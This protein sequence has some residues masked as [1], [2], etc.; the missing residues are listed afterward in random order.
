MISAVIGLG[1]M[2]KKHHSVMKNICTVVTVDPYVS[3]ADYTSV[4]EML[5]SEKID[6]AIVATPT[7]VHCDTAI[8]LL[9]NGIDVLIEKPLATNSQEAQEIL[10]CAKEYSRRVVVGHIE[11][12]NPATQSLISDISDQ[13]VISCNITRISPYPTRINDVGV[14]L[15][16]AIHDIDLVRFITGQN[17][18]TC[19]SNASANVNSVEDTASFFLEM[20]SGSTAVIFDSWL[21][22]FR[23]RSMKITT[24]EAYYEVDLLRQHAVK[25]S[26]IDN[27]EFAVKDLF[28]NRANAL[29]QQLKAFIDYIKTDNI[30]HLC[31]IES[32]LEALRHVE[33]KHNDQ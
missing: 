26:F 20:S 19:T 7:V 14:S 28:V 11:R 18:V 25:Y 21:A 23:E 4:S 6:F 30:G 9:K 29:E 1:S 32:G 31:S 17:I 16:L 22:P 24:K 13:K 3:E 15:D 12:F 8:E 27:S 10:K 33:G 2:G 5:A